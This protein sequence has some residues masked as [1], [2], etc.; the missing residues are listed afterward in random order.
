MS[1]NYDGP[2]ALRPDEHQ[3]MLTLLEAAFG[4][5]RSHWLRQYPAERRERV[6]FQDHLVIARDDR[7]VSH[8]AIYPFTLIVEGTEVQVGGIGSVGT[9]P[10]EQGKGHFSRLM[11]H[12]ETVMRERGY[13][14]A[15]LWG[16]TQRYRHFG[17]EPAGSRLTFRLSPKQ[18]YLPG[19]D[20]EL[21]G[22]EKATDLE[23]IICA[24]E[25]EP[26]RVRRSR[27]RYAA[28]LESHGLQAWVGKDESDWAYVVAS[29]MHVIECGGDPT[30]VARTLACLVHR[31]GGDWTISLP[32]GQTHL[33]DLLY[34]MSDSWRVE[35][36]GQVHILDLKGVLLAWKAQL[37]AKARQHGLRGTFALELAGEQPCQRVTLHC[38][39][40]LEI[41]DGGQGEVLSLS[42]GGM[43][44]FLFGPALPGPA[45]QSSLAVLFPLGF[46]VW[47]LDQV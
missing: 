23:A 41:G 30:C 44:R 14:L 22:Y 19:S 46:Y 9:L 20:F 36:L 43:A 6:V 15:M 26:W 34:P 25:A 1:A 16:D 12:V 28:A 2:R 29:G 5:T 13:P 38:G 17:Y 3:Q 10:S 8:I 4:M 35:P 27:W 45:R 39:D 7:I 24:H 33:V 31:Y 11:R 21:R 42:H 40:G 47:E 18:P 32:E 37:A